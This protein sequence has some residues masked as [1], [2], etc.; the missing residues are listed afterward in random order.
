MS[1]SASG[2]IARSMQ[3]QDVAARCRLLCR[4]QPFAVRGRRRQTTRTAAA[5]RP[6]IQALETGPPKARSQSHRR[7]VASSWGVEDSSRNLHLTRSGH[8]KILVHTARAWT[9]WRHHRPPASLMT[10]RLRSSKPPIWRSITSQDLVIIQQGQQVMQKNCRCSYSSLSKNLGR[11]WNELEQLTQRATFIHIA[12]SGVQDRAQHA[13]RPTTDF[14]TH[15]AARPTCYIY[16]QRIEWSYNGRKRLTSYC[17]YCQQRLEPPPRVE[18][19]K[20]PRSYMR[21]I[22]SRY[23]LRD[24]RGRAGV[25][26]TT[27]PMLS[28][29]FG[30][31]MGSWFTLGRRSSF[32]GML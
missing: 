8:R 13:P 18:S 9:P 4:H 5:P 12:A 32:M 17:Y 30:S 25:S 15:T 21:W 11:S 20:P 29:R 27:S 24:L 23:P 14:R 28:L 1:S 3:D 22:S 16:L 2:A 19:A 6:E 26:S 31:H 10:S 7:Y